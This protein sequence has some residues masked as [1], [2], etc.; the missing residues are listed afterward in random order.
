MD[1]L[2]FWRWLAMV[3]CKRKGHPRRRDLAVNLNEI[4]YQRKHNNST[5]W[6]PDDPEKIMSVENNSMLRVLLYQI[7]C[8][9][10]IIM[11]AVAIVMHR[12]I[13]P[14]EAYNCT[15]LIIRVIW[16]NYS[17]WSVKL[18]SYLLPF[19]IWFA[20]NH[21]LHSSFLLQH[22][23]IRSAFSLVLFICLF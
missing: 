22:Y 6:S 7:C 11:G 18:H 12:I 2:S 19:H 17:F 21:I 10:L 1:I 8:I 20:L 5:K 13:T 16:A 14:F 23:S 9:Y 3:S 4:S 15:I